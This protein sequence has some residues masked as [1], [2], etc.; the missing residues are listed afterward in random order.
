M[1]DR[2]IF[3]DSFWRGFGLGLFIGGLILFV[4]GVAAWVHGAEPWKC[5]CRIN[6]L[7]ASGGTSSGSGVLAREK[8]ENGVWLTEV[9]TAAHVLRGC[10]QYRVTTSDGREWTALVE[11]SNE[12]TDFARLRIFDPHLPTIDVAEDGVERGEPVTWAGYGGGQWE[13]QSGVLDD[14]GDSKAKSDQQRQL[15]VFG[16]SRQGDSG[17]PIIDHRG[18][19]VGLITG[20]KDGV[21]TGPCLPRILPRLRAA[22]K[23]RATCKQSLQ[24][25][26]PT[27][28]LIDIA[29]QAPAGWQGEDIAPAP[30][31]QLPGDRGGD[32]DVA[33]APLPVNPPPKAEPPMPPPPV[34]ASQA[35][36]VKLSVFCTHWCGPCKIMHPLL[37][38]MR[39]EGRDINVYYA[40]DYPANAQQWNVTS[41]PTLIFE[42][43]GMEVNRVK[44]LQSRESLTQLFAE[45]A[46][47]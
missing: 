24:V 46:K 30:L 16:K 9:W 36:H 22:I 13:A 37:D 1:S 8:E 25:Q 26:S 21:L 7:D 27:K 47:P 6:C 42:V 3:W 33:P 43:D 44:G 31:P 32:T 38:A 2:S 20:S 14:F 19:L 11:E 12:D 28:S 23:E 39:A 18:R 35:K 15:I 34:P 40:D 41:Y 17:G 29:P 45:A 4:L 5:A 10:N